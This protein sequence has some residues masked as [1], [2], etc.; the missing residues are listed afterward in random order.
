[1]GKVDMV[2]EVEEKREKEK[3]CA[4]EKKVPLEKGSV[5]TGNQ[6][7]REKKDKIINLN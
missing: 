2:V 5:T 3:Q 4:R 7:K 6:K 1:M